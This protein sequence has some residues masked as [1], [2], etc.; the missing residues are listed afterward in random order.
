MSALSWPDVAVAGIFAIVILGAMAFVVLLAW[1][2]N[3]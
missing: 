3:R 2:A 1:I